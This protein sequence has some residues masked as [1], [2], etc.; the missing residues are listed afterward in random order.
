MNLAIYYDPAFLDAGW[1]LHHLVS[2]IVSA[3][4][5]GIIETLRHWTKV[6]DFIINPKGIR[7][8]NTW[9]NYGSGTS[10]SVSVAP[11]TVTNCYMVAVVTTDNTVNTI[12]S[13]LIQ[14]VTPTTVATIGNS[15]RTAIYGTTSYSTTA[16]TFTCTLSGTANWRCVVYQLSGVD[17]TTP[18]GDTKTVAP[19][20]TTPMSVTLTTTDYSITIDGASQMASTSLAAVN[21]QTTVTVNGR[22]TSGYLLTPTVTSQTVGYSHTDTG[23]NYA[24]MAAAVI[25]PA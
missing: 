5:S 15:P 13:P 1:G 9:T 6:L 8:E 16:G 7:I 23:T 11:T 19:T 3:V 24:T 21:G 25:N 4:Y 2:A 14:G 20:Q 10:V 22:I 17:Q 18:Y 12:S